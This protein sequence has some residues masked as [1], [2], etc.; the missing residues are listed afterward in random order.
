M[1]TD[2]GYTKASR[3]LFAQ[4]VVWHSITLL[5]HFPKT[6]GA[7]SFSWVSTFL[8]SSA[9]S[10]TVPLQTGVLEQS[11]KKMNFASKQLFRNRTEYPCTRQL[12]LTI[13]LVSTNKLKAVNPK[14][15]PYLVYTVFGHCTILYIVFT[16]FFVKIIYFWVHEIVD[17]NPG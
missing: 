8:Q 5:F 7:K 14:L 17:S 12:Y 10:N 15:R 2:L 11:L 6:M 13:T 3:G 1:Q 4:N 9:L 16:V